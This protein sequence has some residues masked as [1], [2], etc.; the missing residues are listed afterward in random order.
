MRIQDFLG[1]TNPEDDELLLEC[2][3]FNKYLYPQTDL[4]KIPDSKEPNWTHIMLICRGKKCRHCL[5]FWVLFSVLSLF[6]V[7]Y[8]SVT[9]YGMRPEQYKSPFF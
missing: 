8:T 2:T 5:L 6:L 9:L 3:Y 7:Q 1:G 4:I